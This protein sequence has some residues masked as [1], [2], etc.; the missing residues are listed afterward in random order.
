MAFLGGS[1]YAMVN[2]IA[3][4]FTI[5][6]PV[7]LKRLKREELDALKMEIEKIQR[8]TRSEHL[9]LENQDLVQKRNRKL[10]R[11]GQ[12]VQMINHILMGGRG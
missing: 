5:L 7:H 6:S 10:L 9:D 3:D 4:G 12:A 1:A 8:N 2:Q 11:L